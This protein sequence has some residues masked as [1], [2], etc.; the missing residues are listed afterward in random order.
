MAA[1]PFLWIDGYDH[2][3]A[4]V[5]AQ[6][7]AKG[8]TVVQ[9]GAGSGAGRYGN[10][11]YFRMGNGVDFNRAL[12]STYGTLYMGI[13]LRTS[14]ATSN[15]TLFKFRESST[16]HIDI[17]IDSTNHLQVTRNGTV[18]ATAVGALAS[19]TWYYLQFK[20]VIHDSTGQ[21]EILVNGSV[22]T[23]GVT[24]TGADTRNGGT[25]VI[26]NVN[27]GNNAGIN[28]DIDDCYIYDAA[29]AGEINIQ[30]VFPTGTGN[31]AQF[32]PST[33]A[34]WQNVDDATPDDDTTYNASSTA[35]HRDLF[36]TGDVPSA[37]GSILA[38]VANG[39][40]RK[41]DAGTREVKLTTRISSTNYDS[42]TNPITSAYVFYRHQWATDPATGLAW[43]RAD[44]NAAEFGYKLEV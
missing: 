6:L 23:L 14:S 34:N 29:Y 44:L 8:Y 4:T 15:T 19:N 22:G 20:V 42:A 31:S 33:G 16:V 43:V 12:G 36:A 7:Q 18:L 2:Y 5:S 27:F 1:I 28:V 25:G 38:V 24:G 21:Y 3:S 13:A 37:S 32:T 30:T 35:G 39:Y 10:G 40:A 17:R 26:D 9:A 11:L 41:D